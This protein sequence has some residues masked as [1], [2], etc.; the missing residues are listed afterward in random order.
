MCRVV[1]RSLVLTGNSV[2]IALN[3]GGQHIMVQT[4]VLSKSRKIQFN[5]TIWFRYTIG[6]MLVQVRSPR[7]PRY[8]C[9]TLPDLVSTNSNGETCSFSCFFEMNEI[10]QVNNEE[11]QTNLVSHRVNHLASKLR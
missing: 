3:F 7:N 1:G 4:E 11:E 2:G 10:L 8:P 9:H 6:P 5:D